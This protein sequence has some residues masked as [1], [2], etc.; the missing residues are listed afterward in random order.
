M[1]NNFIRKL[2]L[3]LTLGFITLII[4]FIINLLLIYPWNPEQ[5]VYSEE[6]SKA[7]LVVVLDGEYYARIDYAF[8]LVE[9]GY[10]NKIFYPNL[11]YKQTRER[12]GEKLSDFGNKLTF[13]EGDGGQST[14]EEAL[15]TKIFCKNHNIKSILLVTSPYHSYRAHWIFSKVIPEVNIIAATVP[16][17]DNWF[18]LDIIEE[19]EEAKRLVKSEQDKFFA[20]YLL[21]GWRC[22]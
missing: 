18:N 20:Y 3:F 1:I 17:E 19:N 6:L 5:I 12:I 4:F 16:F 11:S 2:F 13:F 9:D 8:K 7:D 15:L 10:S 22:W 21:Y 14:Y